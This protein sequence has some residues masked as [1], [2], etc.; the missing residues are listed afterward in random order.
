MFKQVVPISIPGQLVTV[1]DN[2]WLLW[3][4]LNGSLSK[5]ANQEATKES[6]VI[7][8]KSR[9]GEGLFRGTAPT[10]ARAGDCS[11]GDVINDV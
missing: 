9:K 11:T 7:W 6:S 1:P 10:A 8:G 4:E 5:K 2:T 3:A